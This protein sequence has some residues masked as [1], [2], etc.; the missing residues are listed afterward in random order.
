MA[1]HGPFDD[2]Q[3]IEFYAGVNRTGTVIAIFDSF[4]AMANDPR[5]MSSPMAG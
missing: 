1:Q 5:P 2:D 4:E 3:T